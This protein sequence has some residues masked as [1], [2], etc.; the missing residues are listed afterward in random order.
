MNKRQIVDKV[1]SLNLPLG[2]YIVFGSGPLA[3][4]GIRETEDIDMFVA[5]ELYDT[6]RQKGWEKV[7]KNGEDRVLSHE[8]FD[9]HTNWDFGSYTPSLEQLLDTATVIE[10]V[11]FASLDEVKKWKAAYGRPKDLADVEL[12]DAYLLRQ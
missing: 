8:E 7:K 9:V 5:D 3:A 2:T 12:I 4:A 1:A 10:G 11:P 6:L